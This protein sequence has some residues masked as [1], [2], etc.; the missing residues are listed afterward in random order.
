MHIGAVP[1][2]NLTRDSVIS[3]YNTFPLMPHSAMALAEAAVHIRQA[4]C[5]A[6]CEQAYDSPHHTFNFFSDDN[7]LL[8][9]GLPLLVPEMGCHAMMHCKWRVTCDFGLLVP[10]H[11]EGSQG[12]AR[13]WEAAGSWTFETCMR[14]CSFASHPAGIKTASLQSAVPPESKGAVS[15][16]GH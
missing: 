12:A 1:E 11:V 16:V 13:A 4:T 9:S 8:T 14:P 6:G 2:G 15:R 10:F 3:Q 7:T 5:L